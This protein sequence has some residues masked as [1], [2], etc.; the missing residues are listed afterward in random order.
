MKKM[1]VAIA[2]I[3]FVSTIAVPSF[4]TASAQAPQEKKEEK[5]CDK[6]DDKKCC[7]KPE[8]G[9]CKKD[10]TKKCDVKK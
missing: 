2:L 9:C 1:F 4:A 10:S 7:A 5:K 6:K 8:K 3:A